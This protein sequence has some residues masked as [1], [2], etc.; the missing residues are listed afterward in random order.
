MEKKK[1]VVKPSIIKSGKEKAGSEGKLAVLEIS[2]S[3]YLIRED[4]E[5]KVNRLS[6]K[7]G[8]SVKVPATILKPVFGKGFVTYKLL[9]QKK[10]PKVLIMKYKAKSRYRRKRG[11]RADLSKIAVER[12]EV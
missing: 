12:I 5:L 11:F 2:G 3:Q 6:L 9:E 4:S 8:K 1:I 10:G 7:E